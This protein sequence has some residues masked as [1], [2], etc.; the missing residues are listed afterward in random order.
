MPFVVTFVSHILAFL[1]LL[2]NG[3]NFDWLSA[4]VYFIGHIA[5]WFGLLSKDIPQQ[6]ESMDNLQTV[7]ISLY[8]VRYNLDLIEGLGRVQ[9]EAK[10]KVNG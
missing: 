5:S 4:I 3:P 9:V 1:L 10:G 7:F 6:I 2:K 8:Y